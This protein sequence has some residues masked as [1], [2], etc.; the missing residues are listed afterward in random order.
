MKTPIKLTGSILLTILAF[1]GCKKFN[2]TKVYT[3]NQPVYMSY[4]DLRSSIQSDNNRSLIKPG[5]ILVKDNFVFINDFET[6]IHIFN[7][8]NP[9]SPQHIGFINI[10]GNVD[11]AVRGNTLYADSYIDIVAIDISDPTNIR[12]ATRALDELS[13]TIPTTIDYDYPVSGVNR[14]QGVVV[15][16]KVMEVEETCESNEC[17][18]AYYDAVA[19]NGGNWGGSM[20]T[21]DGT[22]V[23]FADNS[24]TVR[25]LS[26]SLSADAAAGSMARFL[27]VKDYLYTISDESTVKVFSLSDN[28]I[29]FILAFNPWSD[30]WGAGSIETLFL[31]NDHLLIGSTSGML[32]YN[33]SDA[34]NPEYVSNYEHMTS[35]DP[36]VANSDYAFVTLRSGVDCGR[37]DIN[38]L[39]IV[40]ISEMMSPYLEHSVPMNNPHGL[41]IDA[42][43]NLLFVC[44]GE[45]GMNVY[46]VSNPTSLRALARRT[47]DSYDVITSNDIVYVIGDEGLVQ[48]SYTEEGQL[49]QISTISLD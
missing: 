16:Y 28:S 29:S 23:N 24:N 17:G 1:S 3:A 6:G 47:G 32:A 34:S 10:P 8:A 48:Y 41:S 9:A 42:E 46:N 7:N 5:K 36:V 13:Y 22:V 38:Q 37:N 4:E 33:V 25:S 20:M 26:G 12:E 35:C 45:S 40:N 44:D 39:D 18:S 43:K 11:M 49:T 27:L 15:D 2:Q 21:D 14:N 31:L 19:V 30:G